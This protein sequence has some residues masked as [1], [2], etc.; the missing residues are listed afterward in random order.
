[1]FSA[2]NC[3]FSSLFILGVNAV[4]MKYC[5]DMHYFLHHMHDINSPYVPTQTSWGVDADIECITVT[6]SMILEWQ[7]LSFGVR[8]SGA[9]IMQP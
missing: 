5:T 2:F 1:M 7:K 3:L 9:A 8:D 6:E 4:C